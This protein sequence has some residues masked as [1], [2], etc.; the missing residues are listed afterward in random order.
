V[1]EY[2]A[3]GIPISRAVQVIT[4]HNYPLYYRGRNSDG[5]TPAQSRTDLYVQQ[6]FKLPGGKRFQ[7]NATVLNL[8]DQ[9][10]VMNRFNDMRRTGAGLSFNESAFYAGQVDVQQ[11]VDRAATS[12]SFRPDPRFLLNSDFQ[13][14]IQARFG[15]K[16][17]F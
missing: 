4:G 10:T 8:F 17:L 16:F 1:N 9:R 3:S 14:A 13:S 12:T 6:E 5:R 15:V 7:V 2:V 11:L